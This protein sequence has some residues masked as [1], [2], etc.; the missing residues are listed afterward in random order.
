MKSCLIAI[1]FQFC[2]T[3]W[4]HVKH[5]RTKHLKL[6]PKFLCI[7]LQFKKAF[8]KLKELI[9]SCITNKKK[10]RGKTDK[11]KEDKSCIRGHLRLLS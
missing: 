8:F 11:D 7:F 9:D 1:A 3:V 10:A 5:Y 2:T 6:I 4:K